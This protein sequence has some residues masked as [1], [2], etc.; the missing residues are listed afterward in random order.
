MSKYD[1]FIQKWKT[2][3]KTMS[4]KAI[5]KQFSV[6]PSIIDYWTSPEQMQKTKERQKKYRQQPKV[7]AKFVERN[8]KYLTSPAG[9]NSVAKSWVRCYL[10]NGSLTL[11][12]LKKILKE[13]A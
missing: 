5:A 10:K 11:K 4:C 1:K 9:K 8:K 7:K 12:D 13:W 6:S 3:R 2:M